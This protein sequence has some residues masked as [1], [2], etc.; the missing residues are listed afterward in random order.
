MPKYAIAFVTPSEEHAIR[1]SI[2]EADDADA[3]LKAFFKENACE[4]YSDNEQGY[5][6]FREDFYDDSLKAGSVIQLG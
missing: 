3:A 4:F 2:L 6:Y 5:H 1:H